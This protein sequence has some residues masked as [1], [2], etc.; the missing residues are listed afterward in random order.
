MADVDYTPES[1]AEH[2]VGLGARPALLIVDMQNDFVDPNSPSSCTP[3]A[4]ERLPAVRS[5]LDA[6]RAAGI[7][8]LFSQGHVAP[9]LSDVGLWKGKSHRTGKI[10]I[11]GTRG[12]A[13]V[14]ELTPISGEYV[15]DKRRPSAFFGTT[16][17]ETLRTLEVDTILLTGSSMSGCVRATAVDGFSHDYRVSIVEECVIDRSPELVERNLFDVNAKYVDAIT[18]EEA[19]QYLATLGAKSQDPVAS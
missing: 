11:E 1:I 14:D 6:A 3:M 8:V 13:I 16:L 5:I 12:A 2:R 9:D 17:L 4:Q 10:Q 19:L 7:P 15:I 18:L